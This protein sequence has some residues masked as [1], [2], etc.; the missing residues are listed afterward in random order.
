MLTL[1]RDDRVCDRAPSVWRGRRRVCVCVL[2]W[3][4]EGDDATSVLLEW[5]ALTS[6]TGDGA[7]VPVLMYEVR[8]DGVA[9][10]DGCLLPS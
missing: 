4:S 5:E 3:S 1:L 7:A 9:H 2:L 6:L 10:H 8:R